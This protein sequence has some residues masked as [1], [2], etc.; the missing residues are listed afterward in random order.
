MFGVVLWSDEADRKAVFWC[1]DQGDLAFYHEDERG[2]SGFCFF[3][4]GDMVQFDVQIE[5]KLRTARNPRLVHEQAC[6]ELPHRLLSSVTEP[7]WDLPCGP[8]QVI[9]FRRPEPAPPMP[10]ARQEP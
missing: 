2:E 8:A 1:E 4:A 5:R 7:S 3:D 9:P 10:R 6:S